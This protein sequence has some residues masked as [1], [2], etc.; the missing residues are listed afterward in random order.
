M[1]GEQALGDYAHGI[2]VVELGP[3]LDPLLVPRRTAISLGLRDEPRRPVI[4]M[5]S[6]YLR[7]KKLLIILDNCEHLLDACAQLADALLK[8]CLNLKILAT[9]REALG[10]LGEA[11]YRVPSLGLPD[12]QQVIEKFR[13]YESVRLFEE[14]AQL[15]QMD[16]LRRGYRKVLICSQ[17]GIAPRS[18]AI[19]RYK[20]PL[21]GA[22]ICSHQ[23]NKFFFGGCLFSSTAGHLKQQSLFVPMRTSDLKIYLICSPS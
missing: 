21:I 5:L 8:K 10:I 17:P 23:Q 13:D 7:V 22:T 16:F 11:S 9:S 12:M 3:L 1:V 6:D 18:R 4:D 20:L 2:W 19:K 15:A 14:R